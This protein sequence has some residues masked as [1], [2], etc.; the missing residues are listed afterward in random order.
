MHK[1]VKLAYCSILI[2]FVVLGLKYLAYLLTGSVALF[3]DA[4]E[5]IVN[6]AA[7]GVAVIALKISAA[8]PDDNHPFGHTKVEYFAA[9]GEGVLIVVAALFILREAYGGAFNPTPLNMSATGLALTATASVLNGFWS[10]VLIRRGLEWRSPALVADGRHLFGDVFTSVGVLVGVGLVFLTGWQL[11]DSLMAASVAIFI[12]WSGWKLI[13]ESVGGLMDE[14]VSPDK[15]ALI[16]NTITAQAE[17]AIEAHDVRT[18]LAGRRIF[19]EFHL[20][21]PGEMTVVQAHEIC[22]RIE[23]S[24]KREIVGSTVHIHIEPEHKAKPAEA[25]V[26]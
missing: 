14:A 25:I 22:D 16:Q 19:I 7:A 18:R 20:I 23:L 11:L 13:R 26:F 21:V 24:L 8:P 17:G 9:V 12:L 4:I 3:S 6:I 5:S 15:L 2:A 10:W 1:T